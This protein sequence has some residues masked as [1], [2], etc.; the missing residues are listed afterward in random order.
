MADVI[1]SI[2]WE[3]GL[4]FTGRNAKGHTTVFDGK[5]LDAASP[6]EILLEA[7]G[8]CAAVDI[9]VVLEKRRTPATRIEVTL[10]GDRHSPEPRYFTEVRPRFDVWG[11]GINAAAVARA[12]R[13]SFT[14]YCSVYHS[15]RSDLVVQAAFRVHAAETEAAGEYEALEMGVPTGELEE[16]D[17]A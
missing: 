11:N 17:E 6:V 16:P 14:R 10:E 12:L 7:L 15:L 9:V 4:K 1:T 8:A 13:L 3:G 2:T 5:T